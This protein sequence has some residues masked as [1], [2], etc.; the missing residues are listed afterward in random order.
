MHESRVDIHTTIHAC[1][2]GGYMGDWKQDRLTPERDNMQYPRFHRDTV[3]CFSAILY[4]CSLQ[5]QYLLTIKYGWT[6][7]RIRGVECSLHGVPWCLGLAAAITQLALKLYNPADW[8][9]W[10]GP[11]PA[12][13]TSSHLPFCGF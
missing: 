7:T 10:I 9:C 5:L 3:Q 12:N 13:C 2:F 1:L 4:M 8:D 6:E 11:Y